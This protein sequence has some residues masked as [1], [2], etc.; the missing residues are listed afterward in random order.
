MTSETAG[1]T[2]MVETEE[3]A[4]AASGPAAVKR[5]WKVRGNEELAQGDESFHHPDVMSNLSSV[6]HSAPWVIAMS[7][8]MM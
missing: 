2:V 6:P 3:A 4:A 7:T 1:Q 8:E 5:E